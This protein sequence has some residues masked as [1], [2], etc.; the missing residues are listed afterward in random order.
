ML[1]ICGSVTRGFVLQLALEEQPE[2]LAM[3]TEEAPSF[4]SLDFA[5]A[6]V[7]IQSLASSDIIVTERMVCYPLVDMR[8]RGHL[9]LPPSLP[10]QFQEDFVSSFDNLLDSPADS[11]ARS[12]EQF[13][14]TSS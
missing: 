13:Q 12:Q 2:A 3:A 5:I 11:A 9:S 1:F 6:A 10:L 4:N 8:H 14:S 7:I